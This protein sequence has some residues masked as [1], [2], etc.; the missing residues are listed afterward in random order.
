MSETSETAAE[1]ADTAERLD[2]AAERP[3]PSK[4]C[5]SI[6]PASSDCTLINQNAILILEPPAGEGRP[7]QV[8]PRGG[9]FSLDQ[10]GYIADKSPLFAHEAV[11]LYE[12]D[13]ED[14]EDSEGDNAVDAAPVEDIDPDN[15]DLND[16]RL[17]RFPSTREDIMD[18]VR[19]LETGLPVDQP[20]FDGQAR[21]PVINMSRRGTEDITGDFLLTAPQ[22]ASPT[23]HRPSK[24]SP[25]G[26]VSSIPASASL[27][28]IS[29]AEE[30]EEE[31][32]F[33]PVVFTN[34][35]KRRPKHLTLP[36]S[37][38]DEGVA[39][40]DG[41]SPRTIKPPRPPIV[42][43]E[44]SPSHS[45]SS[46]GTRKSG[47]PNLAPAEAELGKD[48]ERSMQEDT[49]HPS[50]AGNP[51]HAESDPPEAKGSASS[52]GPSYARVAQPTHAG[53]TGES[54]APTA[55]SRSDEGP[56]ES[57]TGTSQDPGA[58]RPSY[59]GIVASPTSAEEPSES[60]TTSD[61][62]S[63]E[64]SNAATP[65][66]AKPTDSK[67]TAPR[68]PTGAKRLSYAEVAA[69]KPKAPPADDDKAKTSQPPAGEPSTAESSSA[70][71]TA[72]AADKDKDKD[73]ASQLRK[74]GG[75]SGEEPAR[76]PDSGAR[77]PA[78][79][80]KR[81][82]GWIKALLRFFFVDVMGG[83]LRRVL[84]AVGLGG[85]REE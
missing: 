81:G 7:F 64:E 75:P 59:A 63:A 46:P 50:Q 51:G 67:D 74:R 49:L 36:T 68:P 56:T 16:P 48:K 15:I 54:Q 6:A 22:P 71:T 17:E 62:P 23:T 35:L 66:P 55:Q 10:E 80:P 42:T 79:Q 2:Y 14:Q 37:D 85:R 8:Q 33:R 20:S 84:R 39:L 65:Q 73:K 24:R 83:M 43:P 21:S 26:S 13:E 3:G 61:G 45:P 77:V 5:A 34:P 53:D 32:N 30:A 25:R 70:T 40:R 1:V 38:E 72:T 18:A 58:T 9:D 12:S 44:T 29:E 4:V 52:G 69:S 41:V 19:K 76:S 27:H 57:K 60:K 28:S 11:G 31:D 82:G 47:R 78:V